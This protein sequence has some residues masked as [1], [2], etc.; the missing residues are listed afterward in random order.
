M[1]TLILFSITLLSLFATTPIFAQINNDTLNL[2]PELGITL[3]PNSPQPGESVTASLEDSSGS[4]YGASITW[5]I[6][7]TEVPNSRNQRQINFVATTV[8]KTQNVRAVLTKESGYE[9]IIQENIH[10]VYLDIIIE[11]QT[12]TPGFYLGRALP[13]I[14]STINA[15]ALISDTGFYDTD[16]MY[17]WKINNKVLDGGAIRGRNQVSFPAPIG[18]QFT[19]SVQISELNGTIITSR[20]I[21]IPS[22]EPKILF[23]EVSSL[24]GISEKAIAESVIETSNNTTVR[25]EPYNLDIQVYNNPVVHEWKVTN[26]N[27]TNVGNNPYEV[28]VQPSGTTGN[29]LLSFHVRD[30]TQ[31]LQG[32][33]GNTQIN[34]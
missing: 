28:T 9:K 23:Y 3:Q 25:A 16:L 26:G 1:R 10:P 30:T 24:F 32:A 6:D 18:R 33:E 22:V 15:T 34:F 7:G 8:G 20:N 19:L 14:G 4:V 31:F 2:N 11:P 13:S 21:S 12:R 5:I 17:V 29:T 27:Y